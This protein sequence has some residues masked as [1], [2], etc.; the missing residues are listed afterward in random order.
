MIVAIREYLEKGIRQRQANGYVFAA[1][2]PSGLQLRD[3]LTVSLCLRAL[4]CAFFLGLGLLVLEDLKSLVCTKLGSKK[5]H[6][7]NT[8]EP[9][10]VYF[11]S[12]ICCLHFMPPFFS[13]LR[14]PKMYRRIACCFFSGYLYE[15]LCCGSL[16][17]PLRNYGGSPLNNRCR[18]FIQLP[19]HIFSLFILIFRSVLSLRVQLPPDQI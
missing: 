18:R 9:P 14:Y 5:F 6:C 4:Q 7:L 16:Y 11:K 13:L 12:S 1:H 15:L 8:Q 3:L 10:P 17:L 2:S 19:S